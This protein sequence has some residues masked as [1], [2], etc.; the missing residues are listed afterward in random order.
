MTTTTLQHVYNARIAVP[1]SSESTFRKKRGDQIPS[2]NTSSTRK[3]VHLP[4]IRRHPEKESVFE[5][6][7]LN[8]FDLKRAARILLHFNKSTP[9]PKH[10]YPT[11]TMSMTATAKKPMP[12]G[13]HGLLSQSPRSQSSDS[14][15]RVRD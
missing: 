13:S 6:H 14:N 8:D 15:K 4:P 1:L 3:F 7:S 2:N 10:R 5:Q 11:K 12:I 9:R